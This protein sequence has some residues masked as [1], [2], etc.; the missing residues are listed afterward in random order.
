VEAFYVTARKD[1]P[2]EIVFCGK[3]LATLKKVQATFPLQ[4]LDSPEKPICVGA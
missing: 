2:N 4:P 3:F 1:D